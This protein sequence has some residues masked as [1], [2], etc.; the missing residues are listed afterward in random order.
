MDSPSLSTNS[1]TAPLVSAPGS[2]GP[3]PMQAH[4]HWVRA[5]QTR[6][7][8]AEFLVEAIQELLQEIQGD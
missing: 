8:V 1:T 7:K 6:A 5:Q 4:L 2:P 3:N